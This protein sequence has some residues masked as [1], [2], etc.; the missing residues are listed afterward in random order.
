M[1]HPLSLSLLLGVFVCCSLSAQ[2][3]SLGG[4]GYDIDTVRTL[5]AGPGCT[6]IALRMLSHNKQDKP[7]DVFLLRV[8]ATNPYIGFKQ[9]L[10]KDQLVG[11]ERPS[12]MAARYTN[13]TS[14]VVGG[15]NG[16]FFATTG[17]VGKPIGL[18]IGDGEYALVGSKNRRFGGIDENGKGVLCTNWSYKGQLVLADTTLNIHH[19]N[20]SRGE[21]QLVLF[22]RHN[23]ASTNTNAYG[24]EVLVE[25]LEGE[26]WK[27]NGT[28]QVRIM[29]KE[30]N[31]GNMSIPKGQAVLSGHGSKV[32]ALNKLSEGDIV[33]IKFTLLADEVEKN[34]QQS[35]AGDNYALI[36]HDGIVEAENF[37]NETHPRTAYGAS[38]T[39]DTILFCVVDGRS[40][41]SVGCTTH[42]L[43]EI[44][45]YYGAYNAVNW[46]GGGSSCLY[47]HQFGQVNNGSDGTE[48]A[49]A[50][51][52]FAIANVPTEDNVISTIRP[53]E[54]RI[55]LPRFAAY[56]PHFYG[57]NQY[58]IMLNTDV[59][60]VVLSCDES[61]GTIMEDGRLLIS[62]STSGYLQA[63]SGSATTEIYVEVVEADNIAFRLD[64][65]LLDN[66]HTYQVEVESSV[67]GEAVSVPSEVLEWKS[68]TPEVCEVNENGIVQAIDNGYGK[69]VG[70]LFGVYDTILVHIQNVVRPTLPYE[71]ITSATFTAPSG[72]NPQW[73][74]NSI[75]FKYAITRAPFLSVNQK[76]P[77]YGLPD[78]IR[79]DLRT[80]VVLSGI[81]VSLTFNS[82]LSSF[83]KQSLTLSDKTGVISITTPISV[84]TGEKFDIAKYPLWFNG[85]RFNIDTETQEGDRSITIDGITLCYEGVEVTALDDQYVPNWAVYPNPVEG[86]KLYLRGIPEKCS[87]RLYTLDGQTLLHQQASQGDAVLDLSKYAAG[88]YLLSIDGYTYKIVKK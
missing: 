48:R 34:I 51:G 28:M 64:S 42:V 76:M 31:I 40:V 70:E 4:V 82:S 5:Q 19:V 27:T 46:D 1:K 62:G 59:E 32:E 54:A 87:I 74:G 53:Y 18:N 7:L 73:E 44:M 9:I 79:I 60:G 84:W 30:V 77:L 61:L 66:R 14:I 88:N 26:Q 56:Q 16:D 65:V 10:G 6:H 47:L 57:Y 38:V 58:D 15:T 22:N 29:K 21:N 55:R 68:L 85:I 49:V 13:G 11:T 81:D 83:K 23:G 36:V 39:G 63:Q 45:K 12:S 78:S 69:V 72:F 43:G 71:S 2:S 41:R 3:I 50:N 37:W 86:N 8:D 25:L 52:M 75:S 80:D 20:Y 67:R 17:D 24:T 35:V 33:T